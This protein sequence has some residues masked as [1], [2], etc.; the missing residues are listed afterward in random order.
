MPAA[1]EMAGQLPVTVVCCPSEPR[2]VLPV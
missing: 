2:V 1:T